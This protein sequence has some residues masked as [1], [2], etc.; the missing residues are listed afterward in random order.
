MNLGN[1]YN[2]HSF[3]QVPQANMARSAFDRSF[4]AKDTINF[5]EL[6]PIM[7]E[8]ILPGDTINLNVKSF[9]RLAPQVRPMMDNMYLDWYFF[10]VPNRL[11]WDKWEQFNGAQNNPGDST[12]YL[13]PQITNPGGTGYQVGSIFDHM[14]I[15]TG[16]N[17]FTINALPFR[18]YNLIWNQWFRDQNLQVSLNA[19]TSDGPDSAALYSLKKSAKKH[20]YF[21]SCLPW[22]QKGAAVS[23]P[24]GT[25]A[26]VL[27]TGPAPIF[28]TPGWLGGAELVQDPGDRRVYTSLVPGSSGSIAWDDPKLFA[29][30]TTA[31]AATINQFRQAIMLQSLLELD[32][33]GGTRYVEI[34]K[35][36]FNVISPDF[37][38]QRPEF[39][40]SAT[41]TFSQHPLTQTSET[42][43]NN[44]PL[45]QLAAFST[46]A[47]FDNQVGFSKS[48]VEHGWVIGLVKPR[49]DVTYQ[50]GLDRKYSR[51]TRW[52]YF[53]PKLQE[54]G[55]Q[56]V[57]NKEIYI[58]GTAADN[59]V[60]GY[61]ERYA[62]YRYSPSKI[63]GQFRSTY[64][65]S[66]DV[67]HLA[68]EFGNLPAL[69]NAFIQSNTPIERALVVPDPTY[70][71][72]LIDL[73]FQ[74][75]HIRPIMSYGI[76]AT[77]G[78]F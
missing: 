54:L 25:S 22:P 3:A 56:P 35:A 69:N 64:S 77:L 21:T 16:V 51:Q 44:D 31:T 5:D 47:N 14:D 49:A 70:P 7:A 6:T 29:D 10:F 46:Q 67:W 52:D 20:D 40:S 11:V 78:R 74:M 26:P 48:F 43:S 68:E 66:L 37:R 36:H 65:Q 58:Q 30:L 45:G 38:L 50:Q 76:P 34:L 55:E 32:A 17:N 57:Y 27:P 72:V 53:W 61:Q 2:Q 13:V 33:R 60:F 62:E 8:E 75:K 15:P 18:A 42:T 73:F 12:D 23:L 59:G 39:L 1:R 24:I 19:P 28:K 63:R 71:D 9:A 4:G 41:T